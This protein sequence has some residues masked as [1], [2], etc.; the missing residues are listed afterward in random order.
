MSLRVKFVFMLNLAARLERSSFCGAKR[1]KKAGVE[2]GLSCSNNKPIL[3]FFF[4]SFFEFLFDLGFHF[5]ID[6]VEH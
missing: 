5:F 2:D 3:I 4:P 1:N 6:F